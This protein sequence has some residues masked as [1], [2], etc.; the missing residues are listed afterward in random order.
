MEYWPF[1]RLT[2]GD[3][4]KYAMFRDLTALCDLF[5]QGRDA[6]SLFREADSEADIPLSQPEEEYPKLTPE[7]FFNLFGFEMEAEYVAVFFP[8]PD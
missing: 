2:A 5:D 6:D 3:V 1:R 7:E 4:D 8:E